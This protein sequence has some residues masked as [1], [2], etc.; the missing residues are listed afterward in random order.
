MHLTTTRTAWFELSGSF[1]VG[2]KS[3]DVKN[4]GKHFMFFSIYSIE[5]MKI[6]F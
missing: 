4:L 2:E 5:T 1:T 3:F 6:F